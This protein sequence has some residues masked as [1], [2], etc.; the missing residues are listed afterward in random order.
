MSWRTTLGLA[1]L[2]AALVSG[3]SAWRMRDRS[4]PPPVAAQRSDYVLR[5]F[6]M[7]MLAKDGSESVRLKAPELQRSREDES[8]AIV[9]PVFLMPAREGAWRLG[10]DQGWVAPA[11]DLIR[12]EGNVAGVS[13][14]G[15]PSQASLRT[16]RLELLPEQS[17]ARTD[18]RVTLTQ[19]GIIQ[20]GVGME[21]DLKTRNYRLLSQVKV[22]YDPPKR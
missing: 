2:A 18:D 22:R 11:G 14:G 20:T 3:W 1:L 7:V 19:P 16:G 17:L 15:N 9:Q 4:E 10:A 12:L 5:D 8:L 6:E 21:A 13:E